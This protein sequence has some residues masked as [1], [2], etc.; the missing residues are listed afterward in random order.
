MKP[1]DDEFVAAVED[2]VGMGHGAWDM[3]SAET[4][5]RAVIAVYEKKRGEEGNVNEDVE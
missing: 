2:E 4:L 1:V 3:V 5:C